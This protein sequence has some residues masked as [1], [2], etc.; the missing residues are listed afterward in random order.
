M[1]NSITPWQIYAV[2]LVITDFEKLLPVLADVCFIDMAAALCFIIQAAFLLDVFYRVV[3]IVCISM[4]R[5]GFCYLWPTVP[6]PSDG[7]VTNLYDKSTRQIILV[8]TGLGVP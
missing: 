1:G 5:L 6:S 4:A 3:V 8:V 2:L 7:I